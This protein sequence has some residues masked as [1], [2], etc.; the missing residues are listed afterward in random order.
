MVKPGALVVEDLHM[1]Y[2][3][4]EG[5]VRA[6]RGVSFTV[7]P[8]EF[9]TLL[10]ASGCGKTTVLRC[11]AG[12]ESP[13]RGHIA[14]GDQV[15]YSSVERIAEPPYRRDIGMVFQSY[16]IW[17]HLNVFDNVSF[18]LVSGRR[19]FTRQQV[20]ERTMRALNLVHL[21][22]LAYR[23]APFLSGGQQ[24]R[25]ALA[26]ALVAEPAVLL[27]DEPLSNLDA[28]LRAEMRI[29]IKSL[30]KVLGV[31]TLYVTHDQT[32][33][34]TMSDRVAVMKEGVFI[35]EATPKDIYLHPHT[36][37]TATFL[38]ETNLLAGRAVAA[39]LRDGMWRVETKQGV[40][41]CPG[42]SWPH[43]QESVW[44]ACRPEGVII[45]G[46]DPGGENVLTG[47]IAAAMF[48][49]DQ[50]TYSIDLED[51]VLQ[52]KSDP[53]NS[54]QEGDRVFV[55]LP[56]DRCLLIPHEDTT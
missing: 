38:G 18:P 25:V 52:A 53:F 28:K 27:L 51:H 33:A 8:G 46:E 40:L 23:S 16:A 22:E 30:V 36:A 26:R 41:L 44:I 24:Q 56:P 20:H 49:G 42:D 10:G 3:T 9:Y 19:R 17:P 2:K 39:S 14:I 6:V 34:L 7:K 45:T 37:F 55:Q 32:E 4:A 43:E 5:L 1:T 50:I 48:A 15:A 11:I 21:G 54:F 29:E 31:T 35:E 47:R 13:D 12:L